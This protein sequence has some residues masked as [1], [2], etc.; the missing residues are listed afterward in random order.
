MRRTIYI[1]DDLAERVDSYLLEH[2][3][4]TLSALV[5][6]ALDQR[7]ARPSP[8]AILELLGLVEHASTNARDWAEDQVVFQDR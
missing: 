8:E 7:L 3:G 4:T 5:Q 2:P 6:D 1:P